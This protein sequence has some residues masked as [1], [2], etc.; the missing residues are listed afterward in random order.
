MVSKEME[1][2][3]NLL[4]EYQ[5]SQKE[6]SVE[7]TR[8]GLEQLAS[9]SKLPEDVKCEPIDAGGV[10]AEW[11]T[12][13]EAE[14][15]YAILYLHG[16][17]YVAGSIKTH[18]DLASRISRTS[19]ARVLLIDYRLA[20]EHPFPAAVEDAT[21]AYRWLVSAGGIEPN[22]LIVTG[23][24]A[25]GGLTVASLVNLRDEGDTLPAG[26]VCLSPWTDLACTGETLRSKAE[27]D[28]F[29]TP[30]GIEFMAR[31]YLKDADP[32]NPL[33]SPLYA[34][35]KGLPPMLIQVGTSEILL[36]DSL[37]LADRA[38]AAGVNV[39]LDVWEDMIHVF[40][41][42][43]AFAPEGRQAI[44]RIGEFVKKIFS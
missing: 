33:A 35:L 24:S 3:I 18:R 42:F 32:K 9:L 26:A 23:D 19:K 13:P 1:M 41:A 7:D 20:P 12:T 43:A 15:R 44:E 27:V 4:R 16:G 14:A 25:G 37:R 38:K 28:P 5:A 11:I 8:K 40:A 21:T 36:D 10:P 29:I 30:E 34:D 17:G 6:P 39:E 22:N 31:V 2:V